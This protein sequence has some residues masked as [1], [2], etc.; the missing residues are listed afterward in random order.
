M[1]G[2]GGVAGAVINAT[3]PLKLAASSIREKDTLLATKSTTAPRASD[4]LQSTLVSTTAEVKAEAV[5][6]RSAPAASLQRSP[7]RLRP[8]PRCRMA[9]LAS[10]IR[11]PSSPRAALLAAFVFLV[12]LSLVTY[13]VYS[14]GFNGGFVFDDGS[15]IVDNPDIRPETPWHQLWNNDYW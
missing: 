14:S 2:K 6:L 7:A 9:L 1:D 5:H 13:R 11:I 10:G 15:V 12:G 8:R 3:S 4:S